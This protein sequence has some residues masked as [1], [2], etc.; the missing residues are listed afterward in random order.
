MSRSRSQTVVSE[1]P[2]VVGFRHYARFERVDPSQN[3]QRFYTL[4][5]QPELWGGIALVRH[6]GRRGNQGSQRLEGSYPDRQS[7]QGLAERLIRR[8][9]RRRYELV[10]WT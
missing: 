3:C 9:L 4:S 5:W 7:A 8:R 2:A 1:P 6:W 10:D